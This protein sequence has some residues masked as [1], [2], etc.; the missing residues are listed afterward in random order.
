MAHSGCH[1]LIWS[2]A[3]RKDRLYPLEAP[4]EGHAC[5]N[6][7]PRKGQVKVCCQATAPLSS[8][9]RKPLVGWLTPQY[10]QLTS[11]YRRCC[12]W[13]V[14]HV[15]GGLL[16]VMR[17]KCEGLLTG[18]AARLRSSLKWQPSH[19]LTLCRHCSRSVSLTKTQVW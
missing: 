6:H 14:C 13:K 12:T 17:T 1:N 19:V 4:A 16:A 2:D 7:T 5:K 9:A 18:S 15:R 10:R 11:Q 8:I 3:L